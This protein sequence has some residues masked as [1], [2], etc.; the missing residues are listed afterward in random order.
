[1]PQGILTVYVTDNVPEVAFSVFYWIFWVTSNTLIL[2]FLIWSEKFAFSEKLVQ[3]L[4]LAY[5]VCVFWFVQPVCSF[6]HCLPRAWLLICCQQSLTGLRICRVKQ[7][8][9]KSKQWSR[10]WKIILH[11]SMPNLENHVSWLYLFISRLFAYR[12]SLVNLCSLC[13]QVKLVLPY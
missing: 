13:I 3:L 12:L 4:L 9:K 10:T 1:M 11:R 6:S 7:Q 5:H 2:L 8:R